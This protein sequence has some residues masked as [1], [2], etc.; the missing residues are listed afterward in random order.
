MG[1]QLQGWCS[2]PLLLTLLLPRLCTKFILIQNFFMKKLLLF[3]ILSFF[4]T[5]NI[6]HAGSFPIADVHFHPNPSIHP[7]KTLEKINDNHVDWLASG[8]LKGGK[9]VRDEYKAILKER[10]LPLGGQSD[11]NKIFFKDGEEA[12]EDIN[13]PLF[14][15]TIRNLE[16]EL[17]NGNISGIGELFINKKSRDR[18]GRK[19][20]VFAPTYQKILDLVERY[21]GVMQIHVDSD[22]EAIQQLKML[23]NHNPNGKIIWAHCGGDTTASEVRKVLTKHPNIFC[24]L[25]SR[26]PPN[27]TDKKSRGSPN[28]KIF[29]NHNLNKSWKILIEE[30]PNRFMVGTD[31]KKL[32]PYNSAIY[33]IRNGL[34]SNLSK[35]TAK[36]V[37]IDNARR[38]F[39]KD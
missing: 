3:L 8:E 19:T 32:G 27:L 5:L 26:H 36:K 35:E 24:D 39:N 18:H 6:S 29:D 11:F 22:K 7:S 38:I 31:T 15:K 1:R 23:A 28:K 16:E 13:N 12:L 2:Y 33:S 30:F 4:S 9:K 21:D 14:K 25:S 10:Y 34:L 37:A 17:K 20:N